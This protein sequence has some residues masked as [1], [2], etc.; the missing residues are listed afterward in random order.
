M[1]SDA[2]IPTLSPREKRMLRRLAQGKTNKEIA[3]E[4]RGNAEQIAVQRA[5]LIRKLEIQ[6]DEHLISVANQLAPWT[7]RRA[8]AAKALNKTRG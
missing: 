1:A 6:S 7:A 4:I 2:R 5:R 8:L 3:Q